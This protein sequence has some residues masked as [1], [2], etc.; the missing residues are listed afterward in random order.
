MSF[1]LYL[2]VS[3]YLF[4]Y[5]SSLSLSF[6][7]SLSPFSHC[8]ATTLRCSF[9]VQTRCPSCSLSSLTVVNPLSFYFL[10]N[11][12]S[13]SFSLS[14]SLSLSLNSLQSACTCYLSQTC[15]DTIRRTRQSLDT[16][17]YF[18]SLSLSLYLSLSLSLSL[19][20]FPKP[21]FS[22]LSFVNCVFL[23]F[24]SGTVS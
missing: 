6:S 8:S 2:Y 20:S 21:F 22:F 16:F 14:P 1:S 19:N 11:C 3:L 24:F 5:L 23:C 12:R 4:H 10:S 17:I 7:L 13:L 15:A 18:L 9:S